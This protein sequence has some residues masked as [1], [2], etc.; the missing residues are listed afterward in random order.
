[1]QTKS[2]SSL[3]THD[4]ITAVKNLLAEVHIALEQALERR[5]VLYFELA[6]GAPEAVSLYKDARSLQEQ[7]AITHERLE[8][9]E[10]LLLT[11]R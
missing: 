1:M 4:Q 10:R 3:K 7:G 11:H 6:Q 5:V 8:E 2:F 9:I